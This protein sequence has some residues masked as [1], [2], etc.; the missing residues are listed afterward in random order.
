MKK[1]YPI[2]LLVF[3]GLIALVIAF[4][5]PGLGVYLSLPSLIIVVGIPAAL[6]L[7]T[8]SPREIGAAFRAVYRSSDPA[9]LGTAVA[10]FSAMQRYVLWSGFLA[11]M[12]G[13][14]AMLAVL[15]DNKMPIGAGAALALITVLYSIMLNLAV[16]LPFRHAAEKRLATITQ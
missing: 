13:F 10:F 14:V 11:T 8:H 1:I 4:S 6:L 5:G 3:L 7:A 12:M 2:S 16:A 9:E 15:G